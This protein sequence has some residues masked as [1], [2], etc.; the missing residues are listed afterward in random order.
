MLVVTDTIPQLLGLAPVWVRALAER[1]VDSSVSL[2]L[3]RD[4]HLE[5]P[6]AERVEMLQQWA[7]GDKRIVDLAENEACLTRVSRRC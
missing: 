5:P 6:S 2:E 3:W 1:G 7:G 4:A